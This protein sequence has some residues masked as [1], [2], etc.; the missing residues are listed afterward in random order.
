MAGRNHSETESINRTEKATANDQNNTR[1]AHSW[2][3]QNTRKTAYCVLTRNLAQIARFLQ[4]ALHCGGREG[5]K[6]A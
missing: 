1:D 4:I 3:S 5:A 6:A 2:A